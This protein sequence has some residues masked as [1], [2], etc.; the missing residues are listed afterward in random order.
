MAEN[1]VRTSQGLF[2]SVAVLATTLVAIA[3]NR[4][5]LLSADIAEYRE[6]LLSLLLW[7]LTALFCLAV[8]ILLAIILLVVAFW[9]THR[10]WV[11]CT[12]TVIFLGGG[13][14]IFWLALHKAKTMPRLFETSLLELLKDRQRLDSRS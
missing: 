14:A 4:L 13:M 2:H 1:P 9:D 11:L 8:G 7:S 3:H 5:D 10:L 12:L 6:H